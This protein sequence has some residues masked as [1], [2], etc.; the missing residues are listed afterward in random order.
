MFWRRNAWEGWLNELWNSHPGKL[1]WF[2]KSIITTFLR[3]MHSFS[4][5]KGR[6]VSCFFPLTWLL[7]QEALFF[8]LNNPLFMWFSSWQGT[9]ELILPKSIR[10]PNYQLQ[11]AWLSL[12]KAADL[13]RPLEPTTYPWKHSDRYWSITGVLNNLGWFLNDQ[14][15]LLLPG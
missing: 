5:N 10:Q 15:A 7:R 8:I 6:L 14:I 9:G 1:D 13:H 2:P 12:C 4:A 3:D 11:I